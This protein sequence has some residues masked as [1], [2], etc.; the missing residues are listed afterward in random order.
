V[1]S[2]LEIPLVGTKGYRV[3]LQWLARMN[4]DIN[5]VCLEYSFSTEGLGPFPF[6]PIISLGSE[7]AFLV[8]QYNN[9]VSMESLAPCALPHFKLP[10]PTDE[11]SSEDLGRLLS[12]CKRF[13][14]S[15]PAK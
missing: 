5:E 6:G 9:F 15:T 4:V 8:D 7:A 10:H 14:Y 2:S 12:R 13:I 1:A 3:F 11:V